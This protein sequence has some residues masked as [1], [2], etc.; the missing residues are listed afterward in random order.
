M[1]LLIIFAFIGGFVT[2]L[3][4]CILPVLPIVLS[5]SVTGG[6]QRPFGIVTGFIASFTFFTLFLTTLV[7]ATGVSPDVLRNVAVVVILAFGLFMIIPQAQAWLEQIF[8]RFANLG[9]NN[10]NKTGFWGG[11]LIGLSLGLIWA[12]CVGPIL[13]SVITLALTSQVTSAAVIITLAYSLGTAIPMLAITYGGRQLLQKVPWLLRNSGHIQK[14]F[15]VLMIFTAAA[16]FFGWDRQ[17][18]TYVL[19]KFPQY[20]AGLTS[21]EDTEV[22]RQQLD[23]LQGTDET[24][25]QNQESQLLPP[26]QQA[27]ELPSGYTWL[28]SEP[29]KMEEL[30]GKV[31]LIDFWTYSCI[32]CIRTFPYLRDWW[33][34]YE[35]DGLVIIGVHSPEFEFEKSTA[36]V[37][38][39]IQ[40]FQISY[41]VVQDNDFQI[42]K[43]FDN[44]YWPA[45]YLVDKDGYVRY[46]HFGE[47]KY[48]QTEAAIQNLL[49]ID[50]TNKPTITSEET[51][52]SGR[53]SPEIY[54]GYQ[55]ARNYSPQHEFALDSVANYTYQGNLP[56]NSVGLKGEWLVEKE[57]AVAQSNDSE[58]HLN[59]VGKEVYLVMEPSTSGPSLVEV[60]LDGKSLTESQHTSDMTNGTIT[61]DQARKYDLVKLEQNGSHTLQLKFSQ[62]ISAFAFTFGS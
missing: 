22:V 31:V 33:S 8:T 20:G 60:L 19:E 27:P 55:R 35:D 6:K 48:D 49:G 21:I 14:G 30:R 59:F 62:G 2:I 52:R 57:A 23:S 47:G 32:N 15:G 40:D 61:I 41:P 16:I 26:Q 5:G 50:E 39:A 25:N 28:N 43:S 53:Q 24:N 38:Q 7:Q 51:Q 17:F 12:P 37:S 18:Q 1:L 9:G 4:P 34:K 42:W 29:L 58:L 54:L 3:S 10:Q 46:Y 11:M 44:R 56:L 45:K 36:N 13:A